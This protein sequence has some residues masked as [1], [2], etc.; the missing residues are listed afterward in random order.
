MV[1]PRQATDSTPKAGASGVDAARVTSDPGARRARQVSQSSGVETTETVRYRY[2]AYPDRRQVRVLSRLFG[3]VRV[4]YNDALAYARQAHA[5]GAG[6]P[7]DIQ[8]HV[9]TRGKQTP[10]R[11]FLKDAYGVCLIQSVNDAQTAYRNYF[12][13]LSG[14]RKGRRMGL[15]RMKSRRDRYDSARFTRAARF[16]VT[17][18][19]D[20]DGNGIVRL[21]GRIGDLRF[22]QSRPLP[23]EPSSVTVIGEPDGRFYVS[24]VVTRPTRTPNTRSRDEFARPVGVDVGLSAFAHTLTHDTTTGAETVAKI[25]TPAYL[26]RRERALARSQRNLSR[27][28]KGS[29]NRD[30]A[31]IKV[32]RLHRRVREARLDHA[33]QQAA[34]IITNHDFVAVE[35]LNIAGMTRTRSTAKSVHDQALGQFLT[36][37][38][39]KARNRGV[40]L[41]KVGR[42]YPSTRTCSHCGDLT[43]PRGRREL[44][45]REW[46]CTTC[47]THHHRDI[48]AARNILREGLRVH[49]ANNTVADGQSETENALPREC[50]TQ[51]PTGV[52]TQ[53]P[54]TRVG[55]QET[56]HDP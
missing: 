2:R 46:D 37:L 12:N 31:R 13:S 22:I 20:R 28:Q 18:T 27:K 19:A 50:E 30:K 35:D 7:H 47:G 52:Q 33:H 4:V 48:N 44:H 25:D 36:I 41:T 49:T 6:F 29:R 14:R 15:P 23:S 51:T 54:T 55:P 16:T 32:A 42:Y 9:L 45:I 40:T 11:A 56:S 8:A 17:E 26:R 43:G 53:P 10:E 5:S 21:P 3:C 39:H 34:A 1:A 24:F 38:A